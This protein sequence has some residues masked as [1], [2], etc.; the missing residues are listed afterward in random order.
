MMSS[1][2]FLRPEDTRA[3]C[4]LGLFCGGLGLWY[5]ALRLNQWWTK[6]PGRR[7]EN[8]WDWILPLLALGFFAS[9]AIAMCQSG[10]NALGYRDF[11]AKANQVWRAFLMGGVWGA[12]AGV[13][14]ALLAAGVVN[15]RRRRRSRAIAMQAASVQPAPEPAQEEEVTPKSYRSI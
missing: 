7:H 13:A 14:I 3:L 12:G 15:A 2:S 6:R 5:A 10:G 11:N 9:A 1:G 8:I 4:R